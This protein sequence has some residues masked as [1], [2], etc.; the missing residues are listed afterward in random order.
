MLQKKSIANS[1]NKAVKARGKSPIEL[2][3][4]KHCKK[5]RFHEEPE[6][7]NSNTYVFGFFPKSKTIKKKLST[8]TSSHSH[9]KLEL[10]GTSDLM[11]VKSLSLKSLSQ[12]KHTKK[13]D[14]NDTSQET[15]SSSVSSTSQKT[16]TSSNSDLQSSSGVSQESLLDD[17]PQIFLNGKTLLV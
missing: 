17:V 10:I 8:V 16:T 7:K 5:N 9:G 15:T 14:V 2:V 1:L 3:V 13:Y 11:I 12:I 6:Y 4:K